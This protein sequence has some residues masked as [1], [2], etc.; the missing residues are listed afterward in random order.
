MSA[1]SHELKGTW[2]T[3]MGKR[4]LAAEDLEDGQVLDLTITSVTREQAID[5]GTKQPKDLITIHFDKTDRVLAL[6]VTNARRISEMLGTPRVDKW[7]GGRIGLHREMA[8][9]FGKMQ[10]TLRVVTPKKQEAANVRA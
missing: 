7:H 3:A 6:N 1:T 9:A 2:R 8:K 4:Y 5:P 10:P